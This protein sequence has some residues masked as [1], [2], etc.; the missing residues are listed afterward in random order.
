MG[1]GESYCI[2]RLCP[3]VSTDRA[4]EPSLL[5]HLECYHNPFLACMQAAWGREGG[6]TSSHLILQKDT[7]E[8]L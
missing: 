7:Q 3:Q 2:P 1:G 4:L 8:K 5:P 6:E